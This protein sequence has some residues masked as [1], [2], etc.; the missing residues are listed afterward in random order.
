MKGQEAITLAIG[1]GKG[2]VGKSMVSANLA[3]QYAQ[4]GIRVVLLDLDFGA[5]N[6]HTLFGMRQPEKGLGD[7]FTTPR[8][9][10]QDYILPT[11]VENLSLGA[12]NG[13]VPE[14]ANMKY[15]QKQKLIRQIKTLDA[16]LVLL[17]L[18]AGCS[19]NVV[20][21]F[22]MTDASLVV[23]TPEPTAIINAYEFLKNVIYR[24][25]YRMFK[26]QKEILEILKIS[27]APK[28]KLGIHTIADLIAAV[29]QINPWVAENIRS[30]IKGLDYYTI[31]NM[32]RKSSQAH[33]GVKL[34]EIC[35]KHLCLDL[36]YTGII[37]FNEEISTSVFKM[38]PLSYQN[39]DSVTSK[40]L[41]RI[42]IEVFQQMTSKVCTGSSSD[43]FDAQYARVTASAAS[44]FEENL[45][46]Q[47]R[48]QR[49]I[50]KEV[51]VASP[52]PS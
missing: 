19:N 47:R 10:L 8:S 27:T 24:I 28:N 34:R 16:D 32:A 23:T 11:R 42:A 25:L 49:K 9:K 7:Y 38:S 39:P 43:T 14:L 29:D 33:I 46:T 4:A 12:G 3:V 2:G 1:G 21:F 48:L 40:T 30:V 26:Q 35:Q 13:F 51:G 50:D 18:G 36:N 44:D 37:F 15:L 45:L 6:V 17:D 41:K 20:D 22:S 5:A 52:L 31:F